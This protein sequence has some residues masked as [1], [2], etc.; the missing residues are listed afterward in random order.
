ME[1]AC[2]REGDLEP[3]PPQTPETYCGANTPS[4]PP[5]AGPTNVANTSMEINNDKMSAIVM[6]SNGQ[7]SD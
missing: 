7:S 4:P 5:L 1:H 2:G 3:S 6:M